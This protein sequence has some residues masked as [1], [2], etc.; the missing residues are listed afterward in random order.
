MQHVTVLHFHIDFK[1]NLTPYIYKENLELILELLLLRIKY[2]ETVIPS[3]IERNMCLL[4]NKESTENTFKIRLAI[5][6][7]EI[8]TC[9]VYTVFCFRCACLFARIRTEWG[10]RGQLRMIKASNRNVFN[11]KEQQLKINSNGNTIQEKSLRTWK[12]LIKIQVN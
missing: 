10:K 12:K 9:Q 3:N 6:S 8:V 2:F 7:W 4:C 1:W 5:F 11:W